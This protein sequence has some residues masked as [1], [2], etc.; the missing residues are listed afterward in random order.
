MNPITGRSEDKLEK[1][2][3]HG[4][5][6]F[7]KTGGDKGA[8]R[9]RTAV[10]LPL[11]KGE[12]EYI[13]ISG[14]A[15]FELILHGQFFLDAGRREL[16][17]N[18]GQQGSLQEDWNDLLMRDGVRPLVCRALDEF[19]RTCRLSEVETRTLD[20]PPLPGPP[21]GMV[22]R[23]SEAWTQPEGAEHGRQA[24]LHRTDREQTA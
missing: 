20:L 12:S 13:P 3:P 23:P 22:H 18:D 4:A 24:L 14:K 1:A 21:S 6:I 15:C 19:V 2:D 9:I 10:F 5:A 11:A 17:H 7:T 16:Y 8:L